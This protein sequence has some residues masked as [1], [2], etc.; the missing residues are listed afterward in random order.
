VA[1]H[2]FFE[3][4]PL[5]S[6]ERGWLTEYRNLP[7]MVLERRWSLTI[8]LHLATGPK[9]FNSLRDVIPGISANLLARRLRD[10]QSIHLVQHEDLP[11]PASAWVYRLAPTAAEFVPSLRAIVNWTE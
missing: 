6:A 3:Q 4:Q 11:P 5:R 2:D 1:S 10:L 9:R 7:L 8:I